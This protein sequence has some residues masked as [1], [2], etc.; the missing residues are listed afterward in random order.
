MYCTLKAGVT[1]AP[2]RVIDIVLINSMIKNASFKTLRQM[3]GPLFTKQSM[4]M[5]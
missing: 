4:S 2:S 1:K 5:M 3:I